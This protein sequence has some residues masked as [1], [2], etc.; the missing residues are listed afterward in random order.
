MEPQAQP[1]RRAFRRWWVV[2]HPNL[3]D[4]LKWWQRIWPGHC[5]ALR[6]VGPED[7]LFINPRDLVCLVE[8]LHGTP[9]HYLKQYRARGWKVLVVELE[10]SDYPP[11]P[12]IPPLGLFTTCA[13]VVAY[14]LGIST[15]IALPS[16][17]YRTLI[18]RHRAEEI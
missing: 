17:L 10:V 3:S 9:A 18:R 16:T 5:F 13:T 4:K 11:P 6:Q 12:G 14:C 15:R 8:I 7:T 2:F 1:P